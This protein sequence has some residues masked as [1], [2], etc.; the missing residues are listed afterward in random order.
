MPNEQVRYSIAS[1]RHQLQDYQVS[2][3]LDDRR[4]ARYVHV[5][6]ELGNE[7]GNQ[8]EPRPAAS[9]SHGRAP[10]PPA[11]APEPNND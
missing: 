10:T 5:Q 6:G 8:R 1:Y 3:P 11:R 4:L 7:N 9:Q 2:Q